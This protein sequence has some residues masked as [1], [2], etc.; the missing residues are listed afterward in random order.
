[1]DA[2]LRGPGIPSEQAE[3]TAMLKTVRFTLG[4]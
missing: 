4:K 1:M 2:C 3:I